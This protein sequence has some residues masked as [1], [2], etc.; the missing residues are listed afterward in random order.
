MY[1]EQNN[2]KVV[3]LLLNFIMGLLLEVVLFILLMKFDCLLIFILAER[4]QH[5]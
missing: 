1:G 2:C 3:Y 4:A 5:A